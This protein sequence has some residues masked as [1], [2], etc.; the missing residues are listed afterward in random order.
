MLP[1]HHA[2]VISENLA[3]GKW[4]AL[5]G[6]RAR[7]GVTLLAALPFTVAAGQT[8]GVQVGPLPGSAAV[9]RSDLGR[10]LG[11]RSAEVELR[12]SQVER[13]AAELARAHSGFELTFDADPEVELERDLDT[14][15]DEWTTGLSVALQAG[16]DLD[17]D[18]VLRA[19]AA[20]ATAEARLR[21]AQ[22]ADLRS[23]L[24][25]LSD[26]RLAE[27]AVAEAEADTRAKRSAVTAGG[28]AGTEPRELARL[29]TEARLAE[30]TERRERIALEQTALRI[31][32]Y[33][34]PAEPRCP[35][36]LLSDPTAAA[37]SLAV[38]H[39]E[40][41]QLR[42]AAARAEHAWRN[43]PFEAVRSVELT[44]EY[45]DGGGSVAAEVGLRRGVP[46]IGTGVEWDLGATPGRSL[47]LGVAA[48]LT[49]SGD[50]PSHTTL[51]REELDAA[52]GELT[53]F[54]ATQPGRVRTATE[55]LELAYE[56]LALLLGSA[57]AAAQAV[58]LAP[59][60]EDR[61]RSEVAAQRADVA[62]ERAW[63][64]YVRALY[65]YLD[66]TDAILIAPRCDARDENENWMRW[67]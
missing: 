35:A 46:Y 27:Q 63:Q 60:P 2:C 22:R 18:R 57:D 5:R 67:S 15:T 11:G 20:L 12:R 58:T 38:E 40:H 33:G 43:L 30:V 31:G 54:E 45:E 64:R 65:E 17:M 47:T 55:L 24:L 25:V 44:G 28:V 10:A 41:A 36:Q 19:E 50:S 29:E 4:Y 62:A 6:R 21:A 42:I 56:E 9:Y 3:P 49:F 32:S 37:V 61:E 48:T 1:G 66:V 39:G 52:R 34:L 16:V 23:A 53:A 8:G 13:A 26:L 59:T 51:M 14:G 7:V